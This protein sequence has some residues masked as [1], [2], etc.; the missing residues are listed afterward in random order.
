MKAGVCTHGRPPGLW[1]LA[2]CLIVSNLSAAYPERFVW[3]FGWGLGNEADVAEITKVLDSAGKAGLNGAVVSFGLDTL[4]KRDAPYF[5]RLEAVRQVCDRNKLELI[6]TV[7]SVG[8]GG[9]ILSHNPNLAEGLPVVD[10][11]F[12]VSGNEARFVPEA[13]V[14]L[15]NGGFEEFSGNKFRGFGFHDEP[16]KISFADTNTVHGGRASLRLENFGTDAHGHGRVLQ[17]VKVKPQRCYR[18]SVWV[19]TEG[20]QPTSA[21]RCIAL[22]SDRE[23]APRQFNLPA[24][25]DWRRISFLFNSLNHDKVNLYAGLWEGKAGKVWLDDWT[26]EEAGPV[27]V[28]H[29]PGTPVT[30]RRQ[31]GATTYTEGKDYARLASPGF[32][33]WRGDSAMAVLKLLPGSRIKEGERLS[34]SWYHSMLIHDSQV[35]TCMAEPE[36]YEI[37]DHEAKLLAERLKPQR[38]LLG[39]D[40][41]RMGGT[42]QACGGRDMAQ[43]LGECVSKQA[44]SI[45][46]YAPKAQV[47]VWSD[48][49]DPNHNAHPNYYLVQGDFSGSWKHVSTNLVMAVWGGRP[50]EAS[51]KFFA[52]QGFPV[53][54][55][56]YYDAGDLS[57]VKNW[58]SLSKSMSN[59]RGFMYTPWTK[60]YDLLPQ[61]G[62]LLR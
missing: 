9:G 56:C 24:T 10:A 62:E 45:R 15:T 21:F 18:V 26:I 22:V 2:S 57:D 61:F 37:F 8:Y 44:E 36:L 25:T 51:L 29:R 34:V 6:P 19:K 30:V 38:V 40:E 52:E 46:R 11:P 1:L 31:D 27:N 41:V 28:L 55:A 43:L 58:M 5:R 14:Q 48:M 35:T 23:L 49:F 17:A 54:I 60:R 47:Y 32:T 16:G 42:C 20:L 33:V 3:V 7:F 39:T 53:L 13:T 4:C 50:R 59:V 12:V